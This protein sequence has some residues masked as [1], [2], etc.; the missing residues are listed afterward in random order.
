MSVTAKCLSFCSSLQRPFPINLILQ[1]LFQIGQT[2]K[3]FAPTAATEYQWLYAGMLRPIWF[4]TGDGVSVIVNANNV[5]KVDTVAS[6]CAAT[7]TQKRRRGA[8]GHSQRPSK[9]RPLAMAL[10]IHSLPVPVVL[11]VCALL[12]IIGSHPVS[13][14]LCGAGYAKRDW[15]GRSECDRAGAP[16]VLRCSTGQVPCSG[17]TST[18]VAALHLL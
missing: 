16:D 9:N 17:P 6:G 2:R 11:V 4:I 10:R 13:G 7:V 8:S 3:P 5:K 12:M 14:S 18:A 15:I 1:F